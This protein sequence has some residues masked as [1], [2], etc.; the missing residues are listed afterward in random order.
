MVT[1]AQTHSYLYISTT[2]VSLSLILLPKHIKVKVRSPKVKVK[3]TFH[4]IYPYRSLFFFF[5]G[6][7]KMEMGG[8]LSQIFTLF[9]NYYTF[10]QIFWITGTKFGQDF[11]RLLK[12]LSLTIGSLYSHS[13]WGKYSTLLICGSTSPVP[14]G[15]TAPVMYAIKCAILRDFTFQRYE[16]CYLSPHSWEL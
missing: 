2:L 5:V 16:Q 6:R 13:L 15:T 7:K 3:L 4:N 14:M 8:K 10:D 9:C 11:L 12:C 1:G